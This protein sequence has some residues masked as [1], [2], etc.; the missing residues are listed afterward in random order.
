[1]T[2]ASCYSFPGELP[3]Y[4]SI[5]P[6]LTC[7]PLL[8]MRTESSFFNR[9]KK[10]KRKGKFFCTRLSCVRSIIARINWRRLWQIAWKWGNNIFSF[11]KPTDF[12]G[13]LFWNSKAHL[14]FLKRAGWWE[15]TGLNCKIE[16]CLQVLLSGYKVLKLSIF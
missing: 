4:S 13:G 2:I 5:L 11:Y 8:N 6:L 16:N 12:C 9:K 10:K 14:C 3:K 1:M 7:Q 15:L